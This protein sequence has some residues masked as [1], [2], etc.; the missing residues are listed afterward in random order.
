MSRGGERYRRR[1]KEKA[2]EGGLFLS[3]NGSKLVPNQPW[4]QHMPKSAA[5]NFS[6][7]SAVLCVPF[8]VAQLRWT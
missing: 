8:Q 5:T 6:S 1:E 2:P 3:Q 4:K 7:I